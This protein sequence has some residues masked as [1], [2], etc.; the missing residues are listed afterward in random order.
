M[1]RQDARR[2]RLR[3][4]EKVAIAALFDDTVCGASE[5]IVRQEASLAPRTAL[6]KVRSSHV[7]RGKGPQLEDT[8]SALGRLSSC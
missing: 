4:S 1:A 8:G 5:G 6:D 7:S 3:K 2:S